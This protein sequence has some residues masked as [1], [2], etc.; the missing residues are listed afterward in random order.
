MTLLKKALL[1]TSLA[2]VAI[3]MANALTIDFDDRTESLVVVQ[4]G[5]SLAL[6]PGV[7]S[8]G[9]ASLPG[10][11]AGLYTAVNLQFI[12]LDPGTLTVSDIIRVLVTPHVTTGTTDFEFQLLSDGESGLAHPA[13]PPFGV[14]QLTITETGDFQTVYSSH[15][16]SGLGNPDWVFRFASD[17]DAVPEP[18]TLALLGLA[19]ACLGFARRRS[20]GR[21]STTI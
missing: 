4:D 12:V 3:P 19:F 16:L 11:L 14:T 15:D 5:R 2:M 20:R 18:A 21:E 8:V 6:P 17:I 1:A 9:V 10:G 13:P 7:E